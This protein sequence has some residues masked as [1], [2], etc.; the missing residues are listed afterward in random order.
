MSEILEIFRAGLAAADP[1]ACLRRNVQ[2]QGSRLAAGPHA[3]DLDAFARVVAVGGGKAAAG[4]GLALEALIGD[5]LSKGLLALPKGVHAPFRRISAAQAS[6]PLPGRGSERAAAEALALLRD[7][8]EKTLAVCL[9]SGGASAMLAAP[10]PGLTLGDKRR[11]TAL[12]LAGGAS[13]SELNAVRRHLSRVKGGRLAAAAFPAALLTLALS[14]V[15][16]DVPAVIGSGPTVPDPTTYADA[17]AVLDRFGLRE[18][19]P[20]RARTFLE[21]GAAGLAE[22]T[23]KPGD[24]RLAR[25]AFLVVGN[26]RTALEAARARSEE[27]GIPAEIEAAAVQGEA[28]EAGRR[29]AGA[30]LRIQEGMRPGER[31]CRLSGGET[32]VRVQGKGRGGR[33]QELALAFAIAV[34][35]KG[36]LELLSAG[37]DGLDGPT[38][39]AGA[40]VDG[41]TAGRAARLGLDAASHLENNDSYAFFRELD[42]RGDGS[43]HVKTGATGTNVMD[44][45]VLVISGSPRRG[46]G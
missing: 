21:R 16:G 15:D 17:L 26:K 14:D 2:L 32:T 9:L 27:L 4:M 34:A 36:G 3:Y 25:A 30:A 46:R 38:D 37:S 1:S 5:R 41:A 43:A 6:H 7:A 12:L 40:I 29:L 45:Q 13:I 11:V 10:A 19:V 24:Q 35:G 8:D 31:R 18:G 33:N 42:R 39:A 22:E 28:R 20:A 44:L 23:V